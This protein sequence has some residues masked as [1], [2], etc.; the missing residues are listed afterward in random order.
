[1]VD[2]TVYVPAS[3]NLVETSWGDLVSLMNHNRRINID[4]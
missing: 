1:M 2:E 4:L 3:R